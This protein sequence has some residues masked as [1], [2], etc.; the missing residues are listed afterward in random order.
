MGLPVI[1][2]PQSQEFHAMNSVFSLNTEEERV[3]FFVMKS[4]KAP[5]V[6]RDLAFESVRA[7]KSALR[8]YDHARIIAGE[9]TPE[10][11]QKENSVIPK[12]Q[13]AIILTFPELEKCH[14]QD[15]QPINAPE[16]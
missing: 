5:E 15:A 14:V 11:I 7:Y 13:E 4:V 12:S 9:A 3:R 10:Q 6:P 16:S 8:R 2:T 1:L